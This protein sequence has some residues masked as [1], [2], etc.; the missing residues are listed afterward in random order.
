VTATE[1]RRIQSRLLDTLVERIARSTESSAVFVSA[2]SPSTGA[3]LLAEFPSPAVRFALD[4]HLVRRRSHG[5]ALIPWE[6]GQV[7]AVPVLHG[8]AISGWAAVVGPGV[9]HDNDAQALVTLLARCAKVLLERGAADE[10]CD[11]T[12]SNWQHAA[13]QHAARD[14]YWEWDFDTGVMRFSRRALSMLDHRQVDRPTRPDVWFDH[15]HPQDGAGVYA[16]LLTATSSPEQPVEHEHRVVRRDGS[17]SK[18]VMRLLA[19][20]DAAGRPARLIGWLSDVSRLRYV[21]SELKNAQ[22]L[23]DAGRVAASAA[24][25]FSNF[26]TIIR[27]H[28]EIALGL[29]GADTALAESLELIRHAAAG[30]TTLTKQLLTVRRRQTPVQTVIDLNEA[31]QGAERM[32]RSIIGPRIE[33]TIRLRPRSTLVRADTAQLHR[34]LINLVANARDAM[35]DGGV[36]TVETGSTADDALGARQ[37]PLLLPRGEYVT[38]TVHDTGTGMDEA[39]RL[40]IFEPF[41]TTKPLGHGTGLGLWIVRDIIERSGGAIDVRSKPG[42]GTEFVMYFPSAEGDES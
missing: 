38:L 15:I 28:T 34:L 29:V 20:L 39:T 32:I 8:N 3:H 11:A 36:V 13:W 1:R 6:D 4:A 26:L 10:T 31:V 12:R 35:P 7:I 40:H 2:G 19:E 16:A 25:D 17:V 27:G 30:A 9:G 18:L 5:V 24:H 42:A 33:L 37:K 41:Y 23:T 21:E 22:L 14:G